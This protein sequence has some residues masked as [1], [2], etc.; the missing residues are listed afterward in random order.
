[1][2]AVKKKNKMAKGGSVKGEPMPSDVGNDKDSVMNNQGKKPLKQDGWIDDV[3]VKQAQKQSLTKLS[4]PKLAGSDVFSVRYKDEIDQEFQDPQ[5]YKKQ[6]P[7]SM[8]EKEPMKS[9]PKVP[10]EQKQHNNSMKPYAQ[11]GMVEDEI[12]DEHYSSIAAAIMAKKQKMADGGMVNQEEPNEMDELNEAALKEN[13][14]EDLSQP[15]GSNLHSVE[16]DSD[17]HDMI[18][19]I[20]S[21]MNMMR[22]F[23]AQ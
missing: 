10:D 3:T 2:Y 17:E 4:K 14:T 19:K 1:M 15:Q 12:A 16:L 9:G 8:N 23:K 5:G 7:E 13:Y 18:S 20:R 22:Q 21:K 11:G 6:P